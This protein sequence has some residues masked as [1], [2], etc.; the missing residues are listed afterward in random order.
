MAQRILARIYGFIEGNPPYTNGDG[1]AAFSRA[2]PYNYAGVTSIPA[3]VPTIH[4][5]PNGYSMGVGGP[6]VYSVISFP[7]TG[8]NTHGVQLVTDQ[9]ASA[10]NTAANA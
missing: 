2:V 7:P 10:L 4:P 8:L 9:S 3:A 5:L 6:Y 1:Q